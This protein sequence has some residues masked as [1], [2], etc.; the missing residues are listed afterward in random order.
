MGLGGG[1]LVL[2][3]C[4]AT[5]PTFASS[6]RL[7][8]CDNRSEVEPDAADSDRGDATATDCSLD[9]ASG[10]AELGGQ[11]GLGKIFAHDATSSVRVRRTDRARRMS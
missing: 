10:D 4:D 2:G 1:G 8:L 3:L 7:E 11:L 5:G 9:R 6:R